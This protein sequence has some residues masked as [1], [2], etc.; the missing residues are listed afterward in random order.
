MGLRRRLAERTAEELDRVLAV[1]IKGTILCSKVC[2]EKMGKRGGSIIN[3]GS[4]YGEVAA[5]MKIY[6]DSK[7]N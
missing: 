7:I 3:L 5:D 4:I 2:A 6:G 1:N